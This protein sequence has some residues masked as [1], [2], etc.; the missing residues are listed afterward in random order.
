[1]NRKREWLWSGLLATAAAAALGADVLQPPETPVSAK[2]QESVV[3]PPSPRDARSFGI[4]GCVP[5]ASGEVISGELASS[6][7]WRAGRDDNE[8]SGDELTSLRGAK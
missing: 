4:G 2:S 5:S 7:S 1:M 8:L 3:A 6:K